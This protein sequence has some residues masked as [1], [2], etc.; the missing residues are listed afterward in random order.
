[1]ISHK[2]TGTRNSWD[3]CGEPAWNIGVSLK[4]Y[5]FQNIIAKLTRATRV[6]DTLELRHHHLT[7]PTKTPADHIINGVEKLTTAINAAPA[8]ECDNR[9]AAIQALRQA[10]HW[11]LRPTVQ[12]SPDPPPKLHQ[13]TS[14][15]SNPSILRRAQCIQQS[16]K[17]P[18]RV[19]PNISQAKVFTHTPAPSVDMGVVYDE[20]PI[21]MRTRSHRQVI[22]VPL[23]G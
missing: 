13:P 10:F 12:P 6:S 16:A 17:S 7:I 18:P 1:M 4:H 3:F 20:E 15:R 14:I 23:E 8:V 2:K 5:R 22:P 11:W 21:D 19:V 9:L